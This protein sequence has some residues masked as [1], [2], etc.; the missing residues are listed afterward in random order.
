MMVPLMRAVL[1]AGGCTGLLGCSQHASRNVAT[2]G[3][4]SIAGRARLCIAEGQPAP[5]NRAERAPAAWAIT[6]SSEGG[7]CPHTREWR[8]TYVV[9]QPPRHGRITQEAAGG[10]TV[11]SY[12][13]DKGYVGSDR[14]ALRYPS[15]SVALPYLVAVVP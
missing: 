7:G 9:L 12:W 6:V 15:G 10:A 3:S 1:V 13:P 5:L 14:F 11:L 2:G 8:G 4:A